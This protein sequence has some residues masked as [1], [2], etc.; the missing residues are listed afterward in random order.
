M[1]CAIGKSNK[2]KLRF[3]WLK[4][5]QWNELLKITVKG[6][7]AVTVVDYKTR[8]NIIN[9]VQ[10]ESTTAKLSEEQRKKILEIINKYGK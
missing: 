4:Q 2:D 10:Y 9:R 6:E 7:N 5:K 1:S 8:M 3:A